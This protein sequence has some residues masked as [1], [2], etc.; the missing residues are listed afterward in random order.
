MGEV[1]KG[2]GKGRSRERATGG[3]TYT[4]KEG[5]EDEGME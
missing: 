3:A 4:M 5:R 2:K 1:M